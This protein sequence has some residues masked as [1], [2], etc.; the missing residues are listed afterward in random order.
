MASAPALLSAM[1][2]SFCSFSCVRSVV[3]SSTALYNSAIS[4]A[5]A[6]ILASKPSISAVVAAICALKPSTSTCLASRFSTASF[7]CVSHK[8]FASASSNASCSNLAMRS[9][10]MLRTLTK[11]STGSACRRRMRLAREPLPKAWA[12]FSNNSMARA[13]PPRAPRLAAT[14]SNDG[15]TAACC[16]TSAERRPR[17]AR[18]PVSLVFTLYKSPMPFS[19]PIASVSAVNSAARDFERSSHDLA[20]F[21]HVVVSSSRKLWSAF[22]AE[23]SSSI[24]LSRSL[25]SSLFRALNVS[26]FWML[27]SKAAILLA[28]APSVISCWLRS[29]ASSSSSSASLD[30]KVFDRS[31]K[32]ARI[33]DERYWYAFGFCWDRNRERRP[34]ATR[35][36]CTCAKTA[37]VCTESTLSLAVRRCSMARA[38]ASMPSVKFFRSTAYLS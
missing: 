22:F 16:R 34:L 1:A 28:L 13:R 32:M 8:L 7:I 4:L 17:V 29:R 33:S 20:L 5:M 14:C 24:S 26:F 9:L 25:F 38:I 36:C 15:A 37:A 19:V 6:L 21:S 27:A 11:W 12:C 31:I 2:F 10:M 18:K 23:T 3:N 30:L 35:S